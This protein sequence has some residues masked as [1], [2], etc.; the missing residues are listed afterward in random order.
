MLDNRIYRTNGTNGRNEGHH[1]RG[2]KNDEAKKRDD[3]P[4]SMQEEFAE[5]KAEMRSQTKMLTSVLAQMSK[6]IN[7]IKAELDKKTGVDDLKKTIEHIDAKFKA[8]VDEM[9]DDHQKIGDG[10]GIISG[11]VQ[12]YVTDETNRL[13]TQISEFMVEVEAASAQKNAQLK[14]DLSWQMDDFRD[15]MERKF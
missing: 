3:M 9:S 12:N 11:R 15:K 1:M 10:L 2:S 8:L 6:S 14:K 4:K 5:L 7:Q 13:W